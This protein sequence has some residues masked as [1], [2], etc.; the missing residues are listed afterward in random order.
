MSNY[1]RTSKPKTEHI[2]KGFTVFQKT[3]A[4]IASIL[5]LITASITIMNALDNNKN[6]KKEPT[7]SQT[8]TIVKEIQKES[9][10]ENT[11]PTKETNTSQEK[12]Q[13]EETPKSSVKEEKK[14]DQKTATQDSSTPAPTPSKPATENEKQSNTPTSENK[15]NQ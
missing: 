12:T 1:R 2:K 6:I 5:G 3:V 9:P 4:T 14:E 11:S 8:T 13:Q 7:T 10:K 15:T